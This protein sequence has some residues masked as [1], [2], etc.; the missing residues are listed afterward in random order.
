MAE[1]A[2]CKLHSAC[3]AEVR[4][5]S[6]RKACCP[7]GE[8]GCDHLRCGVDAVLWRR[9]RGAVVFR[10]SWL[11]LA[12]HMHGPA[13]RFEPIK[14]HRN[15]VRHPQTPMIF[16]GRV[17]TWQK[18]LRLLPHWRTRPFSVHRQARWARLR[19]ELTKPVAACT[20][21]PVPVF[22]AP[23]AFSASNRG[24]CVSHR[25][26]VPQGRAAGRSRPSDT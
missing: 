16:G 22:I 4:S 20:R 11:L 12:N 21:A 24:W 25:R 1:L 2:S 14:S 7:R 15:A 5:G 13:A 6:P 26:S 10:V 8:H 18:I 19:A 23:H 3:L 9:C 17:A